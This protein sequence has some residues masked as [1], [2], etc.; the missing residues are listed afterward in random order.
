MSNESTHTYKGA[1]HLTPD[2]HEER[3][4]EYN[5]I[6]DVDVTGDIVNE[7]ADLEDIICDANAV[8]TPG[9]GIYS[10]D[11]S[12]TSAENDQTSRKYPVPP[13]SE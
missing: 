9:N 1:E 8:L 3:R 10:I 6:A 7:Y 11:T 12:S 5:Y 4:N 13:Q 2:I